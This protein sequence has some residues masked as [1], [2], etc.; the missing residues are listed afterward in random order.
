MLTPF[1]VYAV[2]ISLLSLF[3]LGFLFKFKGI[4][5]WKIS[6][7]KRLESLKKKSESCIDEKERKA[8][9]YVYKECKKIYKK[10]YYFNS[11]VISLIDF[12]EN[13]SVIY[14]P[15]SKTPLLEIDLG[16]FLYFSNLTSEKIENILNR[17]SLKVVY[18]LRL[19]KLYF[20]FNLINI[21]LNNKFLNSF[22]FVWKNYSILQ[23]IVWFNPL[24][25]L[26]FLSL[27]LLRMSIVK[28]IVTDFFI[29]AGENS[30]LAYS[31]KSE[32]NFYQSKK[33]KKFKFLEK[34][35][36]FKNKDLKKIKKDFLFR[37]LIFGNLPSVKSFKKALSDSALV[38]SASYYPDSKTP[39]KEA[40]IGLIL[41]RTA[42][43][44]GVLSNLSKKRIV[45]YF[46]NIKLSLIFNV[47]DFQKKHLPRFLNK[48]KKI[49]G[50]SVTIANYSRIIFKVSKSGTPFSFL[51]FAGS[52]YGRNFLVFYILKTSYEKMILEID[53]VYKNSQ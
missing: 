50:K 25:L 28:F 51:S 42:H 22:L 11:E 30:I 43:W 37:T 20:G 19:K 32:K 15:E 48:P 41:E 45:K 16:Q 34:K 21:F 36:L 1:E 44:L 31:E 35:K 9:E 26:V 17:K 13:I 29:F 5:E 4:F 7:G 47:Y 6:L 38:V 10:N 3:F 53:Y 27:S 18:N 12:I 23:I 46:F 40:K 33:L 8:Y 49:F 24:T 39:L 14:N 2:I 52:E